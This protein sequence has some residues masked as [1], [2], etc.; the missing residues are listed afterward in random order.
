VHRCDRWLSGRWLSVREL[1]P[2]APGYERMKTPKD[3][4]RLSTLGGAIALAVSVC[5]G[6]AASGCAA[7]SVESGLSQDPAH[8]EGFRGTALDQPYAMPQASLTDTS[9]APY[10]LRAD[11][12]L[13]FGYTH[14]PDL[15]LTQLADVA[16]ALRRAAAEVRSQVTVVFVTTDPARDTPVVIRAFL[17]RFDTHFVGLTGP[18]DR[19]EAA[20]A[21]LGVAVTGK[22]QLPGGGYE[23][24]HGT[25]LI[26]FGADDRAPV[27]WLPGAPIGDLRADLARLVA[28][29]STHTSR[30]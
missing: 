10:D 22:Q 27:I 16:S 24:G 20:A 8:P 13:F 25:Q 9:G 18:R 6:A 5:V 15:C 19:I 12:V 30:P 28:L 23:V 17:N 2:P 3:R 11:T 7:D 4:R 14:C 29:N 21:Q 1:S 26:G